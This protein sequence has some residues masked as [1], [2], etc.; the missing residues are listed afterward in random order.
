MNNYV[1][2][3][4]VSQ[5]LGNALKIYR[6]HFLII[7]LAFLPALPFA[8]LRDVAWGFAETVWV[9]TL[10]AGFDYFFSLLVVPL[11]MTVVV[12]DICVGNP[13]SLLRSFRRL[14]V[15]TLSKLAVTYLWAG[16]P[17]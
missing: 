16:V 14:R 13:P 1:G 15:L 17:F 8:I 6:D 3:K 9:K 10:A 11:V 4:T 5:I 12:S 7:L 2:Q